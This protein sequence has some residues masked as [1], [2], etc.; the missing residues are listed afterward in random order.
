MM[1]DI[2]KLLRYTLLVV[3][4]IIFC[5]NALYSQEAEH[6]FRKIRYVY[7]ETGNYVEE[8]Q[9]FDEQTRKLIKS[10]SLRENN[11]Y[12]D[13]PFPKTEG[14]FL[15]YDL[16]GV[17]IN[18]IVLSKGLLNTIS[19]LPN[20][21]IL[22]G[23]AMSFSGIS[24]SN[25]NYAIITYYFNI[26]DIEEGIAYSSIIYVFN[27]VG[28]IIK[29]V[30]NIIAPI[31]DRV[32]T[33]NGEYMAVGYG[34]IFDLNSKIIVNDGCI[35]YNFK[36]DEVID[37]RSPSGYGLATPMVF[38]N[39]ITII[40][41]NSVNRYYFVFDF[42]NNKKYSKKYSNDIITK[43]RLKKITQTGFVFEVEE[44]GSGTYKTEK[45]TDVFKEEVIK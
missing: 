27:N 44:K 26:G 37:H 36:N 4:T 24:G 35:I 6:P 9:F 45:Y 33:T 30:T 8:V 13:L 17:G 5:N 28:Q 25:S 18:D 38:D 11:P 10:Y 31:G 40:H 42:E 15:T 41:E 32:I 2:L 34:P 12:N 23:G 16:T 43:G 19:G 14:R 29:E 39:L 22:T 1:D 3:L 21:F 7:D 20:N